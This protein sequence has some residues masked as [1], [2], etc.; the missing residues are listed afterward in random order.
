MRQRHIHTHILTALISLTCGI[1][2]VVILAFNLSVRSYIRSRVSVQLDTVSQLASEAWQDGMRDR[3]WMGH[4]DEH[5]DRVTG[6]RGNAIVLDENGTLLAV[7]QADG[8]VGQELAAYFSAEMLQEGV[9]NQTVSLNSGT[10]A[11]S[12][13]KDPND[14]CNFLV[15]YVDVTA[16]SAFTRQVNLILLI[17]VF[18]AVLLSLLLSRRFAR[19]F[20][21]P[22]QDLSEFAAEIGGGRTEPRD[23]QFQDMEFNMLAESM[24]RMVSE[25]HDAKQ[26]Q[27]IFFQNVS[28]EL[29]TPLTSIRGN[30]EGIVCGI[31]EPN[32][33]GKV[34]LSESDKLGGM[35]EDLLFLSRMGKVV[36]GETSEVLDL[37][38]ILSLCVSE[39][40]AEAEARGLVVHYDMDADPVLFPIREQDAIHLFGNLISNALRYAKSRILLT[41]RTENGSVLVSVSDDGPGIAS[42]DLPHVFE[43]FYKGQGGKHGIGL[44]I[45]KAVTDS[46]HGSISAENHDGAVFEV[47]FPLE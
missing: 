36:P 22:V 34:I 25:L 18:A 39:Q 38:E 43:R 15:A 45:A 28:H 4:F 27:E 23:M 46:Y 7:P 16:I 26:K 24:N 33:A 3:K 30:A 47:R 40:R 6:A 20:A 5:K 31:M 2:L 8:E 19:S 41:C 14:N 35:V 32:A 12:V 37:R 1:L 13:L 42:E 29:R 17:V 9:E 44:S 11:I 10:Y 21:K